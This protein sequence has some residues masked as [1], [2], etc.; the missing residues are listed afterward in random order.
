M[1]S[2][3]ASIENR[4]TDLEPGSTALGNIWQV[5]QDLNRGPTNIMTCDYCRTANSES[6]HRCRKCQRR[7]GGYVPTFSANS[8]PVS[9]DATARKYEV[10]TESEAV[11]APVAVATL[12]AVANPAGNYEGQRSVS[13]SVSYPVQRRLFQTEGLKIVSI[14]GS[15]TPTPT[16][17]KRNASPRKPALESFD[18][19]VLD[20]FGPPKHEF[21]QLGNAARSSVYCDYRVATLVH[22][23]LAALVDGS[24]ILFSIALFA[25]IFVYGGGEFDFDPMEN[26]LVFGALLAFLPLFYKMFWACAGTDTPG[27]QYLGLQLTDFDGRVPSAKVRVHRVLSTLLSVMAA[28]IGVIWVYLDEETLS[29]H[30]HISGTF[31]TADL[32]YKSPVNYSASA[33]AD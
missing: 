8:Y 12:A 21:N 17:K 6:D 3:I 29:W 23:S 28:G 22:R 10:V 15:D 2:S 14:D 25:A 26:K 11:S 19:G 16:I 13:G 32:N 7:L 20:F 24:L 33:F 4:S 31:M 27:S 1:L 9:R 5:G 30:D 18:Q